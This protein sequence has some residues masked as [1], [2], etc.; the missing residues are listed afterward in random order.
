MM[1]SSSASVHFNCDEALNTF[2]DLIS[3]KP[4]ENL[5]KRKYSPRRGAYSLKTENIQ[6]TTFI[7]ISQVFDKSENKIHINPSTVPLLLKNL[8]DFSVITFRKSLLDQ[9]GQN[10]RE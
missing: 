3:D 8:I 6:G 2:E 10:S 1:A 9:I 4:D 5:K 7:T